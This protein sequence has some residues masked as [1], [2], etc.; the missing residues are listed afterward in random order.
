[1]RA[2]SEIRITEDR[3][4]SE[5]RRL[6]RA[7]NHPRTI[8][9]I[10]NSDF[11][12]IG[13]VA[14]CLVFALASGGCHFAQ[15]TADLSMQMVTAVVPGGQSGKSAQIDPALLQSEL[16]RYADDFA[17]RTS[18]GLDEY[19]RRVNTP[20]A[21]LNALIWRISLNSSVLGIATGANPTAN[22]IDFLSL[23]SLMR[24]CLEQRATNVVPPGAFDRWLESSRVLETNAWKVAE[25][26]LTAEQQA[27]FRGAI[28]KWLA[29][30]SHLDM[31]F[32][33]RPQDLAA[34]IRQ[35]G[36]K[37]NQSGSVFSLVGLDPTAG[38]DPAVREIT[39]TRIFAE[40]A[41]Y[42]VERMP[43]L[44]N[45]QAE[46]LVQ[47]LLNQERV[48]NTLA[49]VDRLSGAVDSASQ[50]ATALAE[51]FS[52]ER[53]AII[54]ALDSRE[55][56]LRDLS[57]DVT[58]TLVAGEKMSSSVNT[59]L[60]TFDS[61]MKRFGVGEPATTPPDTNSPPFNILDYARTAERIA[62][63]AG[64]LDALIKDTTGTVDTPA[65]DKRIADLNALSG[66]AKGDAKSVLNHGFLLVGGLVL[67]TFVC[68]LAYR[69]LAPRGASA[70]ARQTSA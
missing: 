49:S 10:R 8:F 4:K 59:T 64:Q 65:L 57:G 25:T 6:N 3:K 29:Q 70:P 32:F 30:N 47:Q 40:R 16:L 21:K 63:M 35:S 36:E 55:G 48:T 15:K 43:F 2:K 28:Q 38:L 7:P 67:L 51:R 26:V 61:L 11:I 13:E 46:L 41:L 12:R 37:G 5:F 9:G 17:G 33:R 39:R 60:I 56:K 24:A 66:R 23:S 52:L 27:E 42:A 58:K 22:L 31:G 50:A 44:L 54:D 34:S 18:V 1:M 19:A 45:W 62:V 53:K 68:A 69:R 20:E 14:L